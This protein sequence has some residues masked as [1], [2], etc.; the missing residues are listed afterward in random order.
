MEARP[1]SSFVEL[2]SVWY[3]FFSVDFQR[4]L[5]ERNM[6]FTDARDYL[7]PVAPLWDARDD[8]I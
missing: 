7:S 1:V 4:Y 2:Y 3:F 6:V 8:E 5:G